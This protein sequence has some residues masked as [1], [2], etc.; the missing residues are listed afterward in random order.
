MILTLQEKNNNWFLAKSF[1]LY[2][3][4]EHVVNQPFKRQPPAFL[5]NRMICFLFKVGVSGAWT[6]IPQKLS[7][8][9]KTAAS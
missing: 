9:W 2:A 3:L 4:V 5:T 7:S 1:A 6:V 8:S